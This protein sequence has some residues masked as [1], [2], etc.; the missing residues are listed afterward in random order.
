V[1]FDEISTAAITASGY[2]ANL[3]DLSVSQA[4]MNVAINGVYAGYRNGN[5]WT[6]RAPVPSARRYTAAATLGGK[7]YLIGGLDGSDLANN[8]EY[9]PVANAWAARESM[10]TPRQGPVAQALFGKVYAIGGY[11]SDKRAENEEYDPAANSWVTRAAIKTARYYAASSVVGGKVYVIGGYNND[12]LS[13]N[14]EYDPAANSWVTRAVMPT[15]RRGLAAAAV[16]GK[17][18]AL[19]GRNSSN[20]ALNEEYDPVSDSW[21]TRAAMPTERVYLAATQVGG[22]ILAVGGDTTVEGVVNYNEE[23]DP[24]VDSWITRES[25]PT[26]RTSLSVGAVGGKIFALGGYNTDYVNQNEEYD[27]GVAS[28]FT[29]LTPNTL[30]SFKA[31]FRTFAGNESAESAVVSTYTLAAAS[32]PLAGTDLFAPVG[33][34]SAKVYWSSGTQAG[35]FNGPGATYLV[36]ASSQA[37]FSTITNSSSTADIFATVQELTADTTYYFRV[38]AYNTVGVTDYSFFVLGST[39]TGVAG[40]DITPNFVFVSQTADFQLSW[41]S[42]A[43]DSGTEVGMTADHLGDPIYGPFDLGAFEYQ[44]P[45]SLGTDRVPTSAAIRAY[46]DGKF[47]NLQ[48]TTTSDTAGLSVTMAGNNTRNWLDIALSTW[49]ISG[50]T[51][52]EWGESSTALGSTDTGHVIGDLSAE[53]HYLVKIDSVQASANISGAQCSAGICTADSSGEISF[54]YS[55]DYS[56][57][58]S[59]T[60]IV[61]GHAALPISSVATNVGVSSITANWEPNGN[62]STVFYTVLTSTAS[63]PSAPDGAVVTSSETYNIF[64]SS[65]GLSANTTYYFQVR[66]HGPDG[67]YTAFVSLPSTATLANMPSLSVDTFTNVTGDAIQFNWAANNPEGTLFRVLASTAADPS[68]PDGAVV[69]TSD[70]YNTYLSSSGLSVSTYY[71]FQVAAINHNGVPSAFTSAIGTQTIATSNLCPVARTVCASGCQHTT[72]QA[73]VNYL[74]QIGRAHV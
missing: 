58:S 56:V 68:A 15:A 23:Y 16:S 1:V 45:Y 46:G 61:I 25:M 21:A 71:Y 59:H 7:I 20:Y 72:I 14:E 13:Q 73:A 44:P 11:H 67:E 69:T 24:A 27:P 39:K 5:R 26:N 42:P 53:M 37:D 48:A 55:G 66:A 22:K 62:D 2:M 10:F 65:A 28:S 41:D 19:G 33:Q 34:A 9:D 6:V 60:F 70:T 64:L 40:S 54:T 29:A 51:K 52:K 8:D 49:N 32:S 31:K 43:I 4:G 38:R 63:D 3:A 18:Y 17:I 35:G 74:K 30:Y 36:Q 47:R 12:S 50:D 57:V